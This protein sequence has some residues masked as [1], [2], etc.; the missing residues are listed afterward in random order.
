MLR[1]HAALAF[2]CFFSPSLYLSTSLSLYLF[3][4]LSVFLNARGCLGLNRLPWVCEVV[5][6]ERLQRGAMFVPCLSMTNEKPN[7]SQK[8]PPRPVST[9]QEEKNEVWSTLNQRTLWVG[10][11]KSQE[12]RNGGFS[13]GGFCR[14]H[15]HPQEN[16][17][18][19][20]K[21]GPAVHLALRAPQPREA[22][23]FVKTPLLKPPFSWFLEEGG[24]KPHEGHP[25]QERVLDA[26]SSGAFSI[27]WNPR[28]STPEALS[29]STPEALF[30]G[31]E[32]LSGGCVVWYVFLP[33]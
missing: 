9:T 19:P 17:N 14:I 2:F 11:K 18:Y 15:C 22:N 27:P 26:T 1:L 5:L 24:G 7:P 31:S 23:I 16:K 3:L 10:G 8:E 30:E 29:L 33:P 13:K 25:S 6:L 12:P 21:L 4:R 20:R 28:L 32:N